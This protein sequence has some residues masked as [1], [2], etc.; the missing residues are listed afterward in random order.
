MTADDRTKG[1]AMGILQIARGEG[2]LERVESE[3]FQ[4]G[5]AIESSP[6]LHD[7]LA[8]P[9]IPAE[10]KQAI[11]AEVLGGRAAD[12]TVSIVGL[13]VATGRG[14]DLGVIADAL[15]A[16]S[17]ASRDKEVAIVRSAVALDAD[18]VSRL[19]A[20]LGKATGKKVDVKVVLDPSV[21]GGLV[22]T[23]GDTVIDG[24]V[25]SKLDSLRAAL[26]R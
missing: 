7:A 3:L 9:R 4:V 8:D 10:K 17:A 26:A 21:V 18:T 13:V 1:Y 2:Q 15:A 12:L 5:R 23:V 20:A 25:R 24:S 6:E 19:A 16:E 11:V 14:Q 22:A